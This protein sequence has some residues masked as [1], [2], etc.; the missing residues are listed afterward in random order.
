MRI[1]HRHL[2]EFQLVDWK[3]PAEQMNGS[4]SLGVYRAVN[5]GDPFELLQGFYPEVALE[6]M[7][8]HYAAM[9]ELVAA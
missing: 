5:T 9:R 8:E 2:H 7:R 6:E 4:D 3:S 1:M